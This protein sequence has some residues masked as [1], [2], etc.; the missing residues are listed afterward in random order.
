MQPHLRRCVGL[1][2]PELHAIPRGDH[3]VRDASLT[4]TLDAE[5]WQ[6]G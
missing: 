5:R 3:G 4:D 1:W 6:S 2:N